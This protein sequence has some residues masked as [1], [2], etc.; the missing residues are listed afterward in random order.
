MVALCSARSM[1]LVRTRQHSPAPWR[2]MQSAVANRIATPVR[3]HARCGAP[4]LT[5]TLPDCFVAP[6]FHRPSP[7]HAWVLPFPRSTP[8][9]TSD[10]RTASGQSF[11]YVHGWTECRKCRSNFRRVHG[12]TEC[13]NAG[14]ISGVSTDGRNACTGTAQARMSMDG[15]E[16]LPERRVNSRWTASGGSR[17]MRYRRVHRRQRRRALPH[18][19]L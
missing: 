1:Q 8:H 6:R 15:K 18:R 10:F 2:R 3:R 7:P 11:F 16:C 14:A 9:R 13:R 17:G 19:R 12:W 5:R 4:R